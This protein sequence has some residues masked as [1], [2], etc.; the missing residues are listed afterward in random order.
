MAVDTVCCTDWSWLTLS[1]VRFGFGA[2]SFCGLSR[3]QSSVFV[4]IPDSGV[5]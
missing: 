1:A 4:F 5:L 3:E 2:A